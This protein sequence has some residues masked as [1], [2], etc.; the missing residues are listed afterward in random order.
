V[1]LLNGLIAKRPNFDFEFREQNHK[2]LPLLE[3]DNFLVQE[4]LLLS[5]SPRE[6]NKKKKRQE[7]AEEK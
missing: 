5:V 7:E 1:N 6:K 3:R 2:T 4:R